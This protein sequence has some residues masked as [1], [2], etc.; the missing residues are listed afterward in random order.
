M[1]G[2]FVDSAS[3]ETVVTFTAGD[4]IDAAEGT[5]ATGEKVVPY[6]YVPAYAD[7]KTGTFTVEIVYTGFSGSKFPDSKSVYVYSKFSAILNVTLVY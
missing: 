1:T 7:Q 6:S 2:K 3:T 4:E 5:G